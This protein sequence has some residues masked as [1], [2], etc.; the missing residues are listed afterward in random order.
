MPM[1]NFTCDDCGKTVEDLVSYETKKIDCNCGGKMKR[2]PC[3]ATTLTNIIPSYPGSLKQ[4]AGYMH[5]HGDKPATKIMSGPA[6]C[7]APK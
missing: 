6:G 1:Y 5:T 2:Q 3:F 4:K 7:T